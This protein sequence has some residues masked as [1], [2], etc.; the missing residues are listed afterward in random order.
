MYVQAPHQTP[1][2]PKKGVRQNQRKY[3]LQNAIL[4]NRLL[5]PKK[6]PR[7]GVV[8]KSHFIGTATIVSKSGVFIK[9]CHNID[10]Q[11]W[12]KKIFWC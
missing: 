8:S 10:S 3:D 11:L 6:V 5:T 7:M 1:L 2:P 12:T 4:N 9:E